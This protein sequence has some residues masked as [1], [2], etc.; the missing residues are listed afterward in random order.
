MGGCHPI[1]RESNSQKQ[2]EQFN[3]K[4]INR[5]LIKPNSFI[6]RIINY[7]KFHKIYEIIFTSGNNN[8]EGLIN[9]KYQ[10]FYFINND[11]IHQWKENGYNI[12]K[13]ELDKLK[14]YYTDYHINELLNVYH[15]QKNNKIIN[16][17][18][19][20]F[21]SNERA[22]TDF[23]NKPIYK[24]EDFDCLIDQNSYESFKG[25]SILNIFDI[26]RSIKGIIYD[27]MIILFIDKKLIIKVL[28]RGVL[29]LKDE[30][31]QLTIYCQEY[32]KEG[33]KLDKEKSKEK[34]KYLTAQIEMTNKFSIKNLLSSIEIDL[35]KEKE[36]NIYKY[37]YYI[38][39]EILYSRYPDKN[40]IKRHI[41]FGNINKY[42]KIGL[43]NVGATCYMNATLQCFL[44][45]NSLTT[46]LLTEEIYN[47]IEINEN[48]FSLSRA[49]CHVLEK[50][51]LDDNI[52]NY[53][54]PYEFKDVISA[55]NPLFEGINAND[56]KDLI[57]FLLEDMN[58]ELSQLNLTQKEN[59]NQNNIANSDQTNMIQTFL[60]FKNSF[61]ESNNS[62]ISRNF[63]FVIQTDTICEYCK[64]LK[65]N[66]QVLFLLEFPLELIYNNNI[67]KNIP[68][69]N[70]RGRKFVNLISCFE[71]YLQRINFIGENQLY[72]N[73]CQGLK[74]AY[75]W[76][77]FF[78][79][80]PILVIILNRGKGKTFDCDVDFP[81]EMDLQNYVIRP[82]S[83]TKYKLKGV[84]SH[85]GES[86]M[87]GH[88]I[89]YC[90]HRIDNQWY[91]YNDATV[92]L[93][94]DQK[95]GYIVG[96][97]YILFYEFTDGKKNA[98]Y[99][100]NINIDSVKM[101]NEK[102]NKTNGIN[103]L[104]SNTNNNN[105]IIINNFPNFQ[106]N[107]MNTP[108]NN[109]NNIPLNGSWQQMNMNNIFFN[110][111]QGNNMANFNMNNNLSNSLMNINNN[112]PNNM[113]NQ[114][115]FMNM[116]FIG[117]NNMN[118]MNNF[119][120]NNMMSKSMMIN[121]NMIS[122]MLNKNIIANNNMMNNNNI[123]N[124]LSNN[125]SMNNN[126]MNKNNMINN[127]IG[128]NVIINNN[129]M[130]NNMNNNM[131]N[132]MMNNNNIMNNNMMMN[133]MNNKIINNNMNNN[134]IFNK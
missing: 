18:D 119:S 28:Y 87:S 125:F 53:Y 81:D 65:Y 68:S 99:E 100:K 109:I 67:S 113:Q 72:C 95:K 120:N 82:D 98:L 59:N 130:N 34:Y 3:Q 25:L 69:I 43:T 42:R 133:N 91:C 23:I 132:N 66:F 107:M 4:S 116:N 110:M 41:N 22:Y 77:K 105:N 29:E 121:N 126:I 16:E 122:N 108:F 21:I 50:V 80:P 44:N 7:Y 78:S 61:I 93:V 60:D 63:F 118:N 2:S 30:L 89:A 102:M 15:M 88:F 12:L 90:R 31:I 6:E 52:T 86:S 97:P 13:S 45:I 8:N 101:R 17:Y 57:N 106:N 85:L 96:T 92:T 55:K 51:W 11:W 127:S 5:P 14:I 58:K 47:K 48:L 124:N 128:N 1:R 111:N 71:H 38:R 10:K 35:Y 131:I 9:Y 24:L 83:N 117:M 49:Y 33:G 40:P 75:G 37:K 26:S 32:K 73:N 103:S 20:P 46:Y 36:F 64:I 123:N 84:I 39:N 134:M 62:I 19:I 54:S 129:M 115:N 70:S 79:L 112:N 94:S 104:L 27:K 74:N 76:N 56:S 114:N